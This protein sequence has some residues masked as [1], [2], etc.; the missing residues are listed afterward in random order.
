M[1]IIIAAQRVSQSKAEDHRDSTGHRGLGS[2]NTMC[3]T[4]PGP[5]IPE[6]EGHGIITYDGQVFTEWI[7]A[8]CFSDQH[9]FSTF[10]PR[11]APFSLWWEL[12]LL[13]LLGPGGTV[14]HSTLSLLGRAPSA[15]V[16]TVSHGL[17]HTCVCDPSWAS[18]H[19]LGV[20]LGTLRD[21]WVLFP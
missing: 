19:F 10:H 13:N 4:G 7:T 8:V 14:N 20:N 5:V 1:G 18:H 9:C 21:R 16:I 17:S 11:E 6:T 3:R 2:H 15:R 12:L